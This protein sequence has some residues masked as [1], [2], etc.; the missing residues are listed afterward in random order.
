MKNFNFWE[1]LIAFAIT[2]LAGIIL[3]VTPVL[4]AALAFTYFFSS[5]LAVDIFHHIKERKWP[6]IYEG[7]GDVFA[8]AAIVFNLAC[9]KSS[10]VYCGYAAVACLAVDAVLI[11]IQNKLA[12]KSTKESVK[13][14][15]GEFVK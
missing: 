1:S 8:F 10:N 5:F 7:I 6:S 3:G 4:V 9:L 12:G 13:S 14:V 15:K 2:I 11:F